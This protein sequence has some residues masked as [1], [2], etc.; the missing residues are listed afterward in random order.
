M[1]RNIFLNLLNL[2]SNF[3]SKCEL[4]K[5]V[6]YVLLL[7]ESRTILLASMKSLSQSKHPFKN[8]SIRGADLST[9]TTTKAGQDL[10]TESF[11]KG[12]KNS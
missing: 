2:K 9:K 1:I 6:F 10:L 8:N 3:I 7:K 12:Q 11:A 5:K 4:L